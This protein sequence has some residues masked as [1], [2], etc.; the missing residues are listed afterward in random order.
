MRVS[1]QEQFVGSQVRRGRQEVEEE[2]HWQEQC[3][4]DHSW[5]R[6]HKLL[7]EEGSVKS[8]TLDMRFSFVCM[9]VCVY[10]TLAVP[11]LDSETVWNE[12]FCS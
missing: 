1:L 12:D 2:E 4:G 11:A 8:Y 5:P 10:V 7:W 6:G 3:R 9:Y